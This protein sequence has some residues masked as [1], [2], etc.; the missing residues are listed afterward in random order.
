MKNEMEKKSFQGHYQ[1]SEKT[2]TE[3]EKTFANHISD[4]RLYLEYIKNSYNL[5]VKGEY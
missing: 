4:E 3:W 1:E 5:I 2:T